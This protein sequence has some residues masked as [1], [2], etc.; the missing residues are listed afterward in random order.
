MS[1]EVRTLAVAEGEDGIR[2]DRW[3]RRRWPHLGQAQINRLARS[4]QIRVDGARVKAETRLTAGALVRVPPLPEAPEKTDGPPPLSP[5]DI[6]LVRSLVLHEDELVIALNKPAGL[7]VQGGTKTTRHID[8]LLSAWGEGMERPSLV[9]RLDRDTS[10]VLL[11]AKGPAAAAR[12]A[13]AFA[14]RRAKKT[15]WALVAGNPKPDQGV[16]DLALLK[17]GLN[18]REMVRPADPK[19]VGAETRKVPRTWPAPLA[20]QASASSI[21]ARIETTRS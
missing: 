8:R 16:I 20:T 14:R 3:F 6:R 1:R 17:S 21:E 10:G 13:G 12:Q 15:Y 4:G 5:Q 7:A 11:V 19:E 9:H 2:L 18:D